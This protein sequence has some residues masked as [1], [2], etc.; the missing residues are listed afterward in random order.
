[1]LDEQRRQ[2]KVRTLGLGVDAYELEVVEDHL[3]QAPQVP[4]QE[5]VG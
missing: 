4:L 5:R 1:M 2:H 3:H